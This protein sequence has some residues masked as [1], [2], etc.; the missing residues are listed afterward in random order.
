MG[1]SAGFGNLS[2]SISE[3]DDT[4]NALSRLA[5][6]TND[7]EAKS[8]YQAMAAS[9]PA[10]M[11][12]GKSP[13][14]NLFTQHIAEISQREKIEQQMAAKMAM[15]NNQLQHQMVLGEMMNEAKLQRAEVGANVRMEIANQRHELDLMTYDLKKS[16]AETSDENKKAEMAFKLKKLDEQ[17]DMFDEKLEQLVKYQSSLL[18]QGQQRIEQGNV[19]LGQSQQRIDAKVMDPDLAVKKAAEI[20]SLMKES[21]GFL[22]P[23]AQKMLDDKY[24]SLNAAKAAG[25]AVDVSGFLGGLGNGTN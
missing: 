13:A 25:H 4:R 6:V 21:G 23:G 12:P 18:E 17:K 15:Q 5:S 1:I 16:I 22:P 14:L 24:E 19:K 7:P 9:V 8:T 3:A 11:T 2:E 10:T 20:S